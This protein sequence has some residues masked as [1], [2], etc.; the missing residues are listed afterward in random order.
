[1]IHGLALPG[2]LGASVLRVAA[3]TVK[4]LRGSADRVLRTLL[5]SIRQRTCGTEPKCSEVP[6]IVEDD[7]GSKLPTAGSRRR[8]ECPPVPF[9]NSDYVAV[10]SPRRRSG[11]IIIALAWTATGRRRSSIQQTQLYSRSTAFPISRSLA[12]A[13]RHSFVQPFRESSRVIISNWPASPRLLV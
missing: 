13:A 12:K 5:R 10:R 7:S 6:D 8:A 11:H 9:R 4:L 1:M 3:G 2:S